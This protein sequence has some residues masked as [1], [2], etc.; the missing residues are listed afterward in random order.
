[1]IQLLAAPVLEPLLELPVV[2]L[3]LVV[4]VV[5]AAAASGFLL[6]PL[7]SV[8]AELSVE[9]SEPFFDPPLL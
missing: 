6:S 9:A 3:V 2:E 1:M 4:V 7:L 5:L 8:E